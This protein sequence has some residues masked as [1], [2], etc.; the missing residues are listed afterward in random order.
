[1][2][3][4]SV[5][6]TAWDSSFSTTNNN[7]VV[8]LNRNDEIVDLS[9]GDA[10]TF[11]LSRSFGRVFYSD[12]LDEVIAEMKLP[13]PEETEL[14]KALAWLEHGPFM[15][16]LKLLKQAKSLDISVDMFAKRGGLSVADSV[17]T[18]ALPHRRF[19]VSALPG[20]SVVKQVV[21]DYL[22][23]FPEFGELLD[24]VLHARFATDRRHAFVWLHSP[25]S[26]G[27]GFLLAIFAKLGLVVDV[28]AAE[29][30]KAMAGGPVGL[31][32]IDMLRTWIL[33][34]DEFK[35][36]SSEL[37]LLNR[38]IAISPKNQLRCTVQLY[39]KL[40]ASAENVRSLVGD[41]VEAQFNNRFAYLSPS[42]HDQ[43]LED[44][45][46]YKELGKAVYLGAMVSYVAGYLNV[47]VDRLCAMGA[48]ESSKVADN[49][50]EEYQAERRLYMTFGN[51]DD[52]VVD[53]V[54][55][56]RRCLTAY[57]RWM[58]SGDKFAVAPDVVQGIGQGLLN[59]LKRTALVGY[60]SEGENSKQRRRAIVL[61][62]PVSFVKNYLALSGDRSIVGKMQYKADEIAAKLNTRPVSGGER[63]RVYD[64]AGVCLEIKRGVVVFID[65][66]PAE[67]R[68]GRPPWSTDYES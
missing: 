22:Q 4:E 62:E 38:Q 29:I 68:P 19:E 45:P 55:Q 23:H 33:F 28:Q 17:A 1:V 42:T 52:A 57:A 15:E 66:E 34:V 58:G 8:L 10:K 13:D 6:R 27:K 49:F 32:M 47:G 44:R 26:W 3:D 36:A 18:I 35:A 37:K 48:I 63:V 21:G 64:L 67:G 5:L 61:G 54:A 60:V 50:I 16:L 51:L 14:R 20:A 7:K 9:V 40:F 39:T 59:T 56:I 53:M 46:L 31:S 11:G 24:V 65:D 12:L 25:S 43:K 30:E 2:F 41:G